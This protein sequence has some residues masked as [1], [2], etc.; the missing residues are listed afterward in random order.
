MP[1]GIAA[2]KVAWRVFATNFG[3]VPVSVVQAAALAVLACGVLVAANVLAVVPGLAGRAGHAR[4]SY[5]GP[6][7]E[8]AS[9]V[10]A[11][12][13]WGA[14]DELGVAVAAGLAVV[15]DGHRDAELGRVPDEPVAR[16]DGQRGAQHQQRAGLAGQDV[17]VVDPGR[18][19]FSPKK[20]TSGLSSPPQPRQSTTGTAPRPRRR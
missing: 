13:E 5:C 10:R 1:L 18:G 2:G 19:T 17:A 6:S 4:P 9:S 12:P 7:E 8:L 15:D 11:S 20:I 14:D 3:V 16:H